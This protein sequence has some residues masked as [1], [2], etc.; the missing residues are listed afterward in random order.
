MVSS[1]E[2]TLHVVDPKNPGAVDE[3]LNLGE[4]WNE[5][6]MVSNREA[7]L[8]CNKE[9]RELFYSS[10]HYLKS[11]KEMQDDIEDMASEALD[12]AAFNKLLLELKAE[13]TDGLENTG[14][15]V[16]ARHLFDSAIT[17]DGVLDY[18]DTIVP[19]SYR[20]FFIK[21]SYGVGSMEVIRMLADEYTLKGYAVEL[22]HQP[23]NP[24]KLQ[25]M[26]VKELSF[27]V[28]VN[29]KLQDTADRVIDLDEYL[30]DSI[31]ISGMEMIDKDR[32]TMKLLMA[33][34][35][36]RINTAKKKHDEMEKSYVPNMDFNAITE[37]R[38]KVIERIWK[39]LN[40]V[41]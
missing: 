30:I 28:T 25:T 13:L 9:V 3:I 18:I 8:K 19:G 37:L 17:P 40:T 41:E 7:I 27:A 1:V 34:A 23:L 32:E 6:G 10:Y 12:R 21:S 39:L 36:S 33:E 35:I 16:K 4:Y 24:D 31:L 38:G 2:T 22:Y 20:C 15:A 11:A 14:E 29:Q 26:A 5:A